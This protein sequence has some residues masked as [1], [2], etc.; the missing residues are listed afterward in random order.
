ME[1]I[2]IS[3][4]Q[5]H[6]L[7]VYYPIRGG[8]FNRVVDYVY[9]VDDISFHLE[10]G[11]TFGLIGESGSGKSTVGKAI[12]GLEKITSG[13]VIYEGK[14]IESELHKR[15]SSFRRDIQMI[16]QDVE[17][18]LNPRKRVYDILAEPIRN[19]FQYSIKEEN[20]KISELL[21]I[22]RL[23]DDSKFKYPHEFSGGQ[24]QRIGIARAIATKPK[25]IIADEPVSALDLSVQAQILNFMKDIQKEM[26]I[27][28][29]F[30]SHDLG[31]VKHMC[32]YIG[33]MYKGRFVETG[34]KQDI[35]GNPQH[36]Y[37]KRLLS[38]I[39]QISIKN[40]E[41]RRMERLKIRKEYE[42]QQK[43][44]FDENGRVYDLVQRS[45]THYVAKKR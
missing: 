10:Q 18:S 19:Y 39:P 17:S 32:D 27:S 4:L 25:I 34:T 28:Y 36:I 9:A 15:K 14:H 26:N 45:K 3:F 20:R 23:P 11:K 13:S 24:K 42:V 40:R 7:K 6:N 38:S 41:K 43:E 2:F 22:V 30:I 35:Y 21:E 1:G 44:Y 8:I 5:I 31:I 33:I 29:I 12:I 16:F 37:T